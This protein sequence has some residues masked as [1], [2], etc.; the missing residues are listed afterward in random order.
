M[1]SFSEIIELNRGQKVSEIDSFTE[2]RLS[3]ICRRMRT[4]CWTSACNT[5]RGGV[6]MKTLR[7]GLRACAERVEALDP[8]IYHARILRL[9]PINLIAIG[10]FSRN[11][12]RRVH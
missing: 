11:R 6:V 1:T 8:R 5:R 10:Q 9:Y 2:R 12:R 3:V 7:P 4:T